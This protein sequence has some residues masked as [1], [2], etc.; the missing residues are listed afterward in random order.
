MA[1]TAAF[2]DLD[3]TLINANSARLWAEAELRAGHIGRLDMIR[4][5]AWNLLYHFAVIDIEAAFRQALRQYTGVPSSELAQRTRTWFDTDVRHRLRPGAQIA[6]DDH[7]R[8]GHPLVLLTSASSYEAELAAE[9]WSLDGWLANEFPLDPEGRLT[10][11]FA[12]PVCYGPGKVARAE[13]WAAEHDVDL[14]ASYFYT[15]SYSDLP[16]LERVGEPRIICPD[17]R[18]RRL[19]RRRAW[20]VLDWDSPAALP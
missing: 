5:L 11:A 16:M 8:Q 14:G 15:D 3:R 9:A 1:R 17:P 10:G 2:F 4:A 18:L 12:R 13:A 19:A 7:R 20:P 6:L